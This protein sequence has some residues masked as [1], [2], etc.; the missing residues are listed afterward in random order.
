MRKKGIIQEQKPGDNARSEMTLLDHLEVFR[1]LILRSLGAVFLMSVMAFSFKDFIFNRI[2]LKPKKPGFWTNRIFA[3]FGDFIGSDQVKINQNEFQLISLK[4]AGQFITHI[5]TAIIAGIILASPIV[6]YELWR[7]FKPV[8]SSSQK[9]YARGTVIYSTLLFMMGI[10]FGYFLIVPLSLHFLGSYSI[11]DAVVN[12]IAINSYINTVTSISLASGG[13]FLLPVFV[14]FLSKAGLLTPSFMKRYRRHAYVL[15]LLIAAI[16]TP[17]DI[18]SQILVAIPLAL[19][20]ELGIL[21]S[22]KV[23][24]QEL[25]DR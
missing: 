6:F 1:W 14:Y 20:Y 23:I 18:F 17:P 10:M 11:S 8:I 13:V 25:M 21:I 7:F 24:K 15:M 9:R 5:W 16:I 4:M 12:Q 3:Q 2:I 22:K 19:L